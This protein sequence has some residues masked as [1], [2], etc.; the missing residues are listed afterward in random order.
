MVIRKVI[1]PLAVLVPL[2]LIG[3]SSSGPKVVK[4]SGTLTYKGAAVPNV[5][6]HFIPQDGSRPSWGEPDE[7]GHFTLE[8][9][10]RNKGATVGTHK[11]SIRMKPA[12]T[13]EQEAVMMGRPLPL[14]KE[15]AELAKKYSAEKSTVE[16]K[17]DKA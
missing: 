13:A 4:V 14:S 11:V 10:D 15:R 1:L 3:C 5:Y 16:V 9:D 8:Y 17:I 2:V 6:I 12:T 7:Q